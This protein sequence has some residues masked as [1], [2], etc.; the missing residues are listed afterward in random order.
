VSA[1][2]LDR[3]ALR[4]SAKLAASHN[5]NK[6]RDLGDVPPIIGT[7]ISQ[8]EGFPLNSYWQRPYTY[9]DADGNNII[10]ANEITV[11]DTA[12]FIGPNLPVNEY[13]LLS[14]LGLFKGKLQL[15][16]ALD[17]KSGHYQLNGTERIRCESRLNCQGE[18]DPSA[19]LWMQARVVALR[20]TTARTQYG[21]IEKSAFTRLREVSATWEL[22]NRVSGR[23]R[24]QRIS[25]TAAVRNLKVWSPYSGIDPEAGYFEGTDV[26]T[27]FQTQAPP[28]YFTLR[29]NFTF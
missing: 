24:A 12:I 20:E 6:I 13:T 19:P 16:A 10:T 21:F 5:T 26:Q 3:S 8:K 27:D 17:R 14:D 25:L 29:A 9:N 18:V 4:W 15:R 2:L 7:T 1:T 23:M 22:P 11:G 28:T